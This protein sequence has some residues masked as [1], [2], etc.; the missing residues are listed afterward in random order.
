[1]I[2]CKTTCCDMLCYVMRCFDMVSCRIVSYHMAC[3]GILYSSILHYVIWYYFIFQ[4]IILWHVI[5]FNTP[6]LW[7]H[8]PCGGG[9]VR[10]ISE[11]R[12]WI[13][14][15]LTWAESWFWAVTFSFPQRI[16]RKF[17]STSLSSEILRMET[18]CNI[19]N[20]T[21]TTTTSTSHDQT[22]SNTYTL[23]IMIHIIRMEPGRKRRSWAP[24]RTATTTIW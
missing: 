23:L 14:E 8:Q 5:D 2:C 13:S 16:S 15:G 1:M 9:D 4:H 6:A 24:R 11:L 20:N 17:E 21:T 12:F 19:N 10:Q 22:N 7:T 18:G 3:H